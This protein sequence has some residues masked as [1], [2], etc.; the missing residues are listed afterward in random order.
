MELR[1][2]ISINF[3]RA[4]LV[5]YF[6]SLA[7]SDLCS[8]GVVLSFHVHFVDASLMWLN[9]I[10][11]CSLESNYYVQQNSM[12]KHQ[13]SNKPESKCKGV[14]SSPAILLTLI[15]NLGTIGTRCSS[16]SHIIHP[17]VFSAVLPLDSFG[18]LRSLGSFRTRRAWEW[19]DF[20]RLAC[21]SWKEIDLLI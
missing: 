7:L 9:F 13:N 4:S 5:A 11:F 8:T 10:L 18:A 6:S 20:A 21:F 3:E 14:M 12:Q 15:N 17:V 1:L 16:P 2:I 19:L